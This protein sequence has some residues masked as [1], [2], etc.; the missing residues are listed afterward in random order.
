MALS[1]TTHFLITGATGFVGA[2]MAHRLA[3]EGYK[4]IHILAR[5]AFGNWRIR[6]I[7]KK[8]HIHR[9]D[10]AAAN[11]VRKAVNSAK[12]DIIFHFANIGIYGGKESP[13]EA[14]MRVNFFG[15]VNL[16]EA[17]ARVPYKLFVNTGS[18]S[19]YGTKRRAMSEGDVC[20][21]ES[22]YGVTKLMA[23]EYASFSAKTQKKPIITLR[24][25]SPFGPFDDHRRLVS[26]AIVRLMRG[27]ELRLGNPRAVRDYIHVDD[28]V[29]LYLE[30]ARRA[31]EMPQG[32]VFNVGRGR[33]VAA[34]DVVEKITHVLAPEKRLKWGTYRSHGIESAVWRADMRKTFRQF[35]WRPRVDIEKGIQETI[36]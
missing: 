34:G 33:E 5:G 35:I 15:L 17:L 31:R 10:I 24:L 20:S 4:H 22:M 14:Y 21:P 3:R 12:P 6:G 23:T 32:G 18:S 27:K 11:A 2:N 26:Q 1:K 13:D 9:A 19:E 28:I 29:D 30:A 16:L 8:L 7:E 25:F 36:E